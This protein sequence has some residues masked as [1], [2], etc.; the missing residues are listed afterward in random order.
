MPSEKQSGANTSSET[1]TKQRTRSPK[2]TR[3]L[4]VEIGLDAEQADHCREIAASCGFNSIPE[5]VRLIIDEHRAGTPGVERL[6]AELMKDEAFRMEV[7][8][9]VMTQFFESLIKNPPKLTG[10][11]PEGNNEE[12]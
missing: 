11:M 4:Y 3:R 10:K 2:G 7:A 8:A 9:D 12:A 5:G 1:P 6:K